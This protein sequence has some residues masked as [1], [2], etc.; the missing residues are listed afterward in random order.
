M[1]MY[2]WNTLTL[3]GYFYHKLI[4]Q[5]L[6]YHSNR[7]IL[8]TKLIFKQKGKKETFFRNIL[9]IDLTEIAKT[10]CQMLPQKCTTTKLSDIEKLSCKILSTSTQIP[11]N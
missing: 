8:I 11:C 7:N 9:H 10:V 2:F 3:G 5:I 4:I 6:T 1:N